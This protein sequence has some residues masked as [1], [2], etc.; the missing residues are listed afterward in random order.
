MFSR[1]ILVIDFWR[2][3]WLHMIHQ[4]RNSFPL[5]KSV[6]NIRGS[7]RSRLVRQ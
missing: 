4:E 6:V 3:T 2:Q 5:S 7:A 1:G